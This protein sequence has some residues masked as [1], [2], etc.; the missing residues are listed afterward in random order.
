MP[1]NKQ[2]D[3]NFFSGTG[4]NEVDYDINGNPTGTMPVRTTGETQATPAGGFFKSWLAA[5]TGTVKNDVFSSQNVDALGNQTGG[6]ATA[7]E[8]VK[9]PTKSGVGAGTTNNALTSVNSDNNP[10]PTGPAS[11]VNTSAAALN[12]LITTQP[13]QLDQYTSYTYNIAWYLLSPTQYNAMADAQ[14]ANTSGWQLLMQSG[15]A[16]VKGRSPAFPVDYYMDDLEIES[17]IPFGGTNMANSATNIRFKVTEPNGITLLQ[18]IFNAVVGVYK[19]DS[20]SQTNTSNN[21]AP[22]AKAP[23]GAETPNYLA[24]QYC[25]VIE[26]FGYDQNGKLVAPAKGAFSTTGGYGQSAVIVKY[27]PFRIMEIKFQV[28][29]KIIEYSITG[30]SIPQSYNNTTDRGTIPFPFTMTGQTVEQLLN[31]S[32]GASGQTSLGTGTSTADP[33]TRKTTP[34]PVNKSTVSAQAI[35]AATGTD[36]NAVNPEGMAFGGGGL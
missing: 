9:A 13:N 22:A 18:S 36:I 15:G 16:P 6:V 30:K 28:A 20:Q 27:Y 8:P 19:N 35:V 5:P 31:G 25:L 23:T 12:Q 14:K 11:A 10:K 34:E 4:I 7:D 17:V 26:F 33:G 32:P 29:N 2:N 1:A 24:A 3:P 21:G